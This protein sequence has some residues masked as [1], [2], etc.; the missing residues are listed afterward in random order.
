M[1]CL[2]L[3]LT[4]SVCNNE[5]TSNRAAKKQYETHERLS[6]RWG[7]FVVKS[8]FTHLRLSTTTHKK[9][10]N[11]PAKPAATLQAHADGSWGI[12]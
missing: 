11:E 7:P 1:L 4:T 3:Q 2:V 8:A 12:E 9:S 10:N 5:G 6:L